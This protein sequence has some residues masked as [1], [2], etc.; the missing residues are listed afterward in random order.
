MI[1]SPRIARAA[2]VGWFGTAV[3]TTPFTKIRSARGCA[4]RPVQR[5]SI[6]KAATAVQTLGLMG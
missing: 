3:Q 1:R 2:A 5:A 6:E 4:W